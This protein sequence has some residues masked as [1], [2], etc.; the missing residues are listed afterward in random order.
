MAITSIVQI[1]DQPQQ[2]RGVFNGVIEME[3][4]WDPASV[5][6]NGQVEESVA[7]P[8]AELGDIV[9]I[10][11]DLDLQEL[12][13]NGYVKAANVVDVVLHNTTAGAV[14]LGAM[15]FHLVLL[16]LNHRHA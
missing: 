7:V 9:L 14:D 12:L 5:G 10:S 4:V 2:F 1:N 15:N 6:S 16:Q 3:A 11:A 13:L 8:G